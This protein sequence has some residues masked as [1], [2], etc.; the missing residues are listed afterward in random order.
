MMHRLLYTRLNLELTTIE[1]RYLTVGR[2]NY[3]NFY[4]FVIYDLFRKEI[5]TKKVVFTVHSTIVELNFNLTDPNTL[6]L[7]FNDESVS[8][9]YKKVSRR[10]TKLFSFSQFKEYRNKHILG[11]RILLKKQLI[12]ITKWKMKFYTN[13]SK[14]IRLMTDKTLVVLSNF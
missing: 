12:K 6:E 11:T 2:I 1:F 3:S 14:S 5:T 10:G 13:I 9:N 7:S 4:M 8:V